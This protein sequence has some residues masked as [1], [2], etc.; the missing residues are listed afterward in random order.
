MAEKRYENKEM[1]RHYE[2][3]RAKG[4]G[5]KKSAGSH[6][7]EQSEH[8]EESPIEDVV[9]EHGPAEHME[10]HSHHEDGHVHKMTHHDAESAHHH[11]AGAFEEEPAEE[12]DRNGPS[13]QPTAPGPGGAPAIPTMAS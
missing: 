9:A 5:E 4:S 8:E 13:P 10:I 7:R 3:T 11:V 6:N 2:N 12:A 1:Q